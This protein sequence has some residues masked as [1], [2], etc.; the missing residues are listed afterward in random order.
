MSKKMY[1]IFGN[2]V[3]GMPLSSISRDFYKSR[4]RANARAYKLAQLEHGKAYGRVVVGAV[5]PEGY[6]S[7]IAVPFADADTAGCFDS[8][9]RYLAIADSLKW[10]REEQVCE[11]PDAANYAAQQMWERIPE[12]NRPGTH[13]YACK[14][15]RANIEEWALDDLDGGD[16]K[17]WTCFAEAETFPGAFEAQA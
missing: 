13:V 3:E 17:A 6:A 14:V 4:D 9:V 15:T 7:A 16:E 2:A 8:R 11:S 10:D 5:D 12:K 1:C